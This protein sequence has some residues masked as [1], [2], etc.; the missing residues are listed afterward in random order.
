MA[1]GDA[2]DQHLVGTLA[3]GLVFRLSSTEL[4]IRDSSGQT[5]S[6]TVVQEMTAIHRGGTDVVI[7]RGQHDPLTL[8]FMRLEEATMLEQRLR[9]HLS[10]SVPERPHVSWW[11]RLFRLDP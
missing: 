11:R 3:N 8:T 7:M 10:G 6:C 1:E 5:L 4:V 2:A 9:T